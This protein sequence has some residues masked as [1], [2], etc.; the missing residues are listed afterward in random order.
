MRAAI[1]TFF[2]SGKLRPF[3]G[4]WGT[5]AAMLF[6]GALYALLVRQLGMDWTLFNVLIVALIAASMVV[7]VSLGPWA[8]KEYSKKD[9][10][11][12]VLDEA[13]GYWTA[14]L[15]LPISSSDTDF[16]WGAVLQFFLFRIADIIK[17][18]PAR[19]SQ[20][21]PHGWGI[22]VDDIIAAIYCNIVAQVLFR[23]VWA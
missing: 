2:G 15:F 12:F 17:P 21:L 18:S 9:P 8:E 11:P 6:Y 22:M 14:M 7:G 1:V 13:A 10:S 3:P 16:L 23:T 19:R 20:A 4:T 5:G